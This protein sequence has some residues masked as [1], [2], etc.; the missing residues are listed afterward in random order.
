MM[1][2]PSSTSYEYVVTKQTYMVRDGYKV[3]K[4]KLTTC[5]NLRQVKYNYCIKTRM[6]VPPVVNP[7]RQ[8]ARWKKREK[9]SAN[10]LRFSSLS[11]IIDRLSSIQFLVQ[12]NQKYHPVVGIT[13][14]LRLY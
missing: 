4:D 11:I 2:S 13:H 3:T 9:R 5:S 8:K 7:S 12:S 6:N 14:S 1:A 10:T